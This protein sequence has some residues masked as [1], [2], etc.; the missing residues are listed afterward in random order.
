MN[1]HRTLSAVAAMCLFTLAC[2]DNTATPCSPEWQTAEKW[3]IDGC[4]GALLFA[5]RDTADL[6]P[7]QT[8]T[9]RYLDRWRRALK[10]E[11]IL[12]ARLPQRYRIHGSLTITTTDPKI[13]SAWSRRELETGDVELDQMLARIDASLGPVRDYGTHFTAILNCPYIFNEEFLAAALLARSSTMPDPEVWPRDDGMWVWID[14]DERAGHDLAT[15][16]IDFRFGWGDCFVACDG[17]RNLQAIIPPDGPATVYDLGG[18]PL[19]PHLS[20]SPN[21]KPPP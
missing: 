7:S 19:P 10:A 1:K 12:A 13:V 4:P 11:P 3:Q 17:F 8:E 16:K 20:L 15:A 21:T 14:A 5:S 9:D 18:S 2:G 6:L